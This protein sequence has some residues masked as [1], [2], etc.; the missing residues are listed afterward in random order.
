M[1]AVES[2]LNGLNE[3]VSA[4]DLATVRVWNQAYQKEHGVSRRA[5]TH[6]FGC[7]QNVSDGE[8]LNGLLLSMGFE[9]TGE[10]KDADLILFNTCAVRESAEDRV[11]GHIGALKSL[12]KSKP[13]LILAVCGCMTQRPEAADKLRQS[14]PY[15]DIVFGTGAGHRLPS[16]LARKIR[17]ERRIFWDAPAKEV[18]ENLPAVRTD[19]V[20]ASVTI[21]QG[22]DNFCSYCIVPYVRGREVSRRPQDVLAEIRALVEDGYRE[23]MLLGQNVNS[24]GKG[25]SEQV[26]F[27]DLLAA[28][29]AIEGDYRLRFMTSHPKDCTRKL[30]DTI[31]GAKHVCRHIHLPVQS[32]SDEILKRMNRR[33]TV[34]QYLGLIDYARAVLPDVTFSSDIIVGFPGETQEDFD[35]TLELV[36]TV[37]YNALFTFLYSKRSG[38]PA[39]VMPDDTPE[40]VKSARFR[41]LLDVQVEICTEQNRAFVGK[42]LRVLFDAPGKK[43][44]LIAGRTEGNVIVEV[45][46][47]ESLIGR[48]ADVRIEKAMNWAMMGTIVGSV[49]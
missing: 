45:E 39:A 2:K 10:E 35:K 1:T 28:A 18:V 40:E 7:S 20:K 44:G 47:D 30:I 34:E 36:K 8:K 5:Y 37:H 42:T 46:G 22:C 6:S 23:I 27:S 19:R 14:Y 26:D 49:R 29:D 24:Y 3:A 9:L 31:A 12:K 32:G 21:M 13:S 16:F 41:E 48:F 15:V 17:G 25:L 38:T 33:Y 43:P 11:F 4:A